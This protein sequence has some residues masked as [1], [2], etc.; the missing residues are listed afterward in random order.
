MR[1]LNKASVMSKKMMI[2][3]IQKVCGTGSD[4]T[5]QLSLPTVQL[6]RQGRFFGS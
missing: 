1:P 5:A 6:R 3:P 2:E 4:A